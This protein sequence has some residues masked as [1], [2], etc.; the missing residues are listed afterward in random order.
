MIFSA[1]D[2]ERELPERWQSAS[3]R[4]R[5]RNCTQ[6]GE[7]LTVTASLSPNFF[8]L[9]SASSTARPAGVVTS[10]T[11]SLSAGSFQNSSASISQS[12]VCDA[13]AALNSTTAF[14]DC[15]PAL[16]CLNALRQISFLAEPT[17]DIVPGTWLLRRREY[18]CCWSHL[19]HLAE[20][21]ESHLI[22]AS[23]RLLHV[24][25]NDSDR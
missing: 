3:L 7:R 16:C 10:R 6:S 19:E 25:G 17:C 12:A 13:F 2:V 20:V 24:V 23:R 5:D 18:L 9:A 22:S 11:R 15:D 8:D 21:K 4:N 1:A 14:I